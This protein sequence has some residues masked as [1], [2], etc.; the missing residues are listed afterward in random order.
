MPGIGDLQS[1]YYSSQY[2]GGMS[3]DKFSGGTQFPSDSNNIDTNFTPSD[4]NP[5]ANNPNLQTENSWNE[6]LKKNQESKQEDNQPGSS[7]DKDDK[8]C[9]DKNLEEII[10]GLP[11]IL[12]GSDRIGTPDMVNEA[13]LKN[14]FPILTIGE[15]KL[16]T[17]TDTGI[18]KKPSISTKGKPYKFAVKNENGVTYSISNEYGPSNIEEEFTKIAQ[19]DFVSQLYQLSRSNRLLYNMG[20]PLLDRMQPGIDQS[21]KFLDDSIKEYVTT[22][23]Q[24]AIGDSKIFDSLVG[25]L[26]TLGQTAIAGLFKGAKIDIPNI[27]KGSSGPISYT[28]NIVLHCMSPDDDTEYEHYILDPLKILF[29]LAS[30]HAMTEQG[31]GTA[32]AG[33]SNNDILTYENPPYITAE[34]DGIFKT[35]IGAITNFTVNIDHKYQ[36]FAHGGRPWL[37]TINMTIT[38]LYNVIVWN[39]TLDQ[40]SPNGNDIVENLKNHDRDEKAVGKIDDRMEWSLDPCGFDGWKKD[41]PRSNNEES[42]NSSNI[43]DISNIANTVSNAA[44]QVSPNSITE[45]IPLSSEIESS[46]SNLSNELSDAWKMAT[47]LTKD[48]YGNIS[49]SLGDVLSMDLVNSD[50]LNNILNTSIPIPNIASDILNTISDPS[51]SLKWGASGGNP[52]LDLDIASKWRVKII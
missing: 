43:P 10:W 42:T 21:K 32:A 49:T 46:I 1:E 47:D 44:N 11:P 31:E 33:S 12:F 2:A 5:L 40:I 36:S 23:V 9:Q 29:R 6:T 15:V 34:V 17:P 8:P 20:K 51:I 16:D 14:S 25:G 22:P 39:D 48:L 38:D 13:L 24:N 3:M 28:C 41:I 35:N 26:S 37:V 30:P 19:L 52:S 45:N 18:T 50:L 7:E 4:P 27:W